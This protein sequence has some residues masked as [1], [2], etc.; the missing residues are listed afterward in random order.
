[1]EPRRTQEQGDVASTGHTGKQF[2]RARPTNRCQMGEDKRRSCMWA[3]S[4]NTVKSWCTVR[5]AN[6]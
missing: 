5:R 1:M 2:D 6:L 3:D 4:E